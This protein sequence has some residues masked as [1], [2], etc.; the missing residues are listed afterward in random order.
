LPESIGG[1]QQWQGL[2]RPSRLK[3]RL[4]EADHHVGT[5]RCDGAGLLLDRAERC[6]QFRNRGFVLA[7]GHQAHADLDLAAQGR[8]R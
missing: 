2:W 3:L 4:P 1:H 8:R 6:L 5:R 7:Q